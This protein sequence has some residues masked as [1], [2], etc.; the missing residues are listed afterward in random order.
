MRVGRH[1]IVHHGHVFSAPFVPTHHNPFPFLRARARRSH[2]VRTRVVVCTETF[3]KVQFGRF[4]AIWA[5]L[6]HNHPKSA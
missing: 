2:H 4:G 3:S 6:R 1:V 5:I